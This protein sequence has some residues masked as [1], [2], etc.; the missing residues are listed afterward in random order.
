MQIYFRISIL[1]FLIS[2]FQIYAF[3]GGIG[4][5]GDKTILKNVKHKIL[6]LEYDSPTDKTWGKDI[7][8]MIA[9]E[10][11]GTMF[12]V[13]NMG[14]VHLE[15]NEDSL[16]K[17]TPENINTISN[18][19]EVLL[20]IWG[21]FYTEGNDV[22]IYSHLRIIPREDFPAEAFGLSLEMESDRSILRAEPATLQLNFKPIKLSIETLKSMH[23][24]YNKTIQIRKDPN[25]NSNIIKDL[26][27]GDTYFVLRRENEWMKIGTRGGVIGWIKYEN[28]EE[29]N[30]LGEV[31]SVITMAQA[32]LQYMAG[33]YNA[34]TSSLEHYTES[35][36]GQDPLN[37]CFS[38]IL[39]GNSI[40]YQNKY[41]RRIPDNEKVSEQYQRALEIMP[42]NSSAINHLAI[43]TIFRDFHKGRESYWS[44]TEVEGL[45]IHIIKTENNVNAIGNLEAL[46]KVAGDFGNLYNDNNPNDYQGLI[47]ERLNILGDLKVRQHR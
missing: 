33:N 5:I 20:T 13:N 1:V 44:F 35:N 38:H 41:T 19:Q 32:I 25:S 8:Q 22:Y 3:G 42:Y 34:S 24:F 36:I 7:S 6:V 26:V 27:P 11:L 9:Q 21:E 28:L 2:I 46:Y 47:R 4:K 14:V 30:E 45:L 18:Q 31:G 17:Y 29:Q 37:R 39:F 40:I 23:E 16:V 10:I 12:G 43:V 15:Q